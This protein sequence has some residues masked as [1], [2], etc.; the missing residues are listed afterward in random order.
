VGVKDPADVGFDKSLG[1]FCEGLFSPAGLLIEENAPV[2]W[3]EPVL[4]VTGSALG[5]GVVEI[6]KRTAKEKL[7]RQI[8]MELRYRYISL[9][10]RELGEMFGVDCSTIRQ[11]PSR[12]KRRLQGDKKIQGQFGEIE[13]QIVNLSKRKVISQRAQ[14]S[15]R[16]NDFL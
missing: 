12:L 14:F 2:S 3:V 15:E 16:A 7:F 1:C 5:V 8:A 9:S 11:N 10:Q 4:G 6:L 13:Q